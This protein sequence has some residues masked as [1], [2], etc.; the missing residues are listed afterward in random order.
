M[1]QTPLSIVVIDN[2]PLMRTALSSTL[3]TEDGMQVL[4]EYANSREFFEDA[5]KITPRMILLG[6]SNPGHSELE[7]IRPLR[8]SF[9]AAMIL[10]LV[11]GELAGQDEE[12]L[13]YGAHS[14]L[15]KTISR[16]ELLATLQKIRLSN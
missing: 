11:T 15:E 16:A 7:T 9:P 2:H 8:A 14:V 10:A 13:Q 1:T 5:R 4:A 12:A 3:A 6:I